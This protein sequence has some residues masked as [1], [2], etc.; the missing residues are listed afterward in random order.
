MKSDKLALEKQ[1]K[2]L[3]D[4][5]IKV[6]QFLQCLKNEVNAQHYYSEGKFTREE[7]NYFLS[8]DEC[9]QAFKSIV[10]SPDWKI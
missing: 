7:Y 9:F 10:L 8:N 4:I 6:E 2:E 1:N 3:L 5:L